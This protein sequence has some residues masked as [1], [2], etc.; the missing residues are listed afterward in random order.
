MILHCKEYLEVNGVVPKIF[1]KQ[2]DENEIDLILQH[3]NGKEKEL[4]QV[5]QI[6]NF[7]FD[8]LTDVYAFLTHNTSNGRR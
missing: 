6:Q 3:A 7:V 8:K 4:W 1:Y 5:E 2:G